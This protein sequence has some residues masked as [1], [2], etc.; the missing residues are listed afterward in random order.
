MV[1]RSGGFLFVA[2]GTGIIR[3]ITRLDFLVKELVSDIDETAIA[4]AIFASGI[5]VASLATGPLIDRFGATSLTAG[6]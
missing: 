2:S 6:H 1:D 5:T 3:F 4:L